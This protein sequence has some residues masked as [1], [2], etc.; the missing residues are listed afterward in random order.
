MIT[1][2]T[3]Y[4]VWRTDLSLEQ[5]KADLKEAFMD[6]LDTAPSLS[7]GGV[8]ET[9]DAAFEDFYAHHSHRRKI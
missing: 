4:D 7:M 5:Y 1:Y 8:Q 3:T 6:G 9:F 2:K